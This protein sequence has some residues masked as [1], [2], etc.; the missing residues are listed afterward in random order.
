MGI[1]LNTVRF[2]TWTKSR[3][4]SFRKTAMLGRQGFMGVRP[5]Q[6]ARWQ[7]AAPEGARPGVEILTDPR[8][9]CEPLFKALKAETIHSY[10]FSSYENATHLWDLNEAPPAAS[11]GAY[12]VVFDGGTLEHVFDFP[13]ALQ[14]AL[15]LLE[16]GGHY[17]SVTPASGWFGHGFYQFSAELFQQIFTA[18]NGCELTA[19]MMFE[20]REDAAIYEVLPPGPGHERHKFAPCDRRLSRSWRGGSGPCLIAC[21]RSSRTMSPLGRR[22]LR[23]LAPKRRRWRDLPAPRWQAWLAGDGVRSCAAG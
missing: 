13:R 18:G 14:G 20:D 16:P 12:S 6:L 3:G 19:L 22:V 7:S 23:V 2:L 9:Y 15:Q 11:L 5:S 21:G 8:Q 10:D 4:V 17:I 1:D